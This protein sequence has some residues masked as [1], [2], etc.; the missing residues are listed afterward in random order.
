[1]VETTLFIRYISSYH[2][3]ILLHTKIS[4]FTR[5]DIF[6][7]GSDFALIFYLTQLFLWTFER[8]LR[9]KAQLALVC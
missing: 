1:M 6:Q 2:I 5:L 9:F 7:A 4:S 8:F 3:H